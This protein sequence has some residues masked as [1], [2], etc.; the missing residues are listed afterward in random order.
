[1]ISGFALE[2][3]NNH[4]VDISTLENCYF[5]IYQQELFDETE[6]MYVFTEQNAVDTLADQFSD[7]DLIE[8]VHELL[9]FE[10][11][12]VYEKFPDY[13]WKGKRYYMYRELVAPFKI[14]AG[15][16]VQIKMAALQ[17]EEDLIAYDNTK[18]T[19]YV[20]RNVKELIEGY[21]NAYEIHVEFL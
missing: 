18:Q 17:M 20:D 11:L 7:L 5:Q 13:G 21:A 15:E 9:L 19:Y 14:L 16:E 2:L 3:K 4:N 12:K 8:E 6:T 10:E 1:M